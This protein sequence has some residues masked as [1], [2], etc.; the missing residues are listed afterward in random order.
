M[1]EKFPKDIVCDREDTWNRPK[2]E[3]APINS[4]LEHVRRSVESIKDFM[5][6]RGQY[7]NDSLVAFE[8]KIQGTEKLQ[9]SPA[10]G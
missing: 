8:K 4:R 10:R 6:H 1:N 5:V 7:V 2:A 3:M 9:L